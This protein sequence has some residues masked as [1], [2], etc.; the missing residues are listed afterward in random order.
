MAAYLRR[1]RDCHPALFDANVNGWLERDGRRF[2]PTAMLVSVSLPDMTR[3]E[4]RADGARACTAA[5]FAL[6][7]RR[8]PAQAKLGW[9]VKRGTVRDH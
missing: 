9:Q 3:Q 4:E 2:F 7:E 6:M 5:R 1:T 8:H